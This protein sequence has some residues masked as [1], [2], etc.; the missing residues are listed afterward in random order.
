[1]Q[2]GRI[3]MCQSPRS[4]EERQTRRALARTLQWLVQMRRTR[5]QD[6]VPSSERESSG[7]E[8]LSTLQKTVWEGT[9]PQIKRWSNKGEKSDF[10]KKYKNK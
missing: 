6:L 7:I 9:V 10:Y 2:L 4:C 8:L 1:M 5:N 3:R